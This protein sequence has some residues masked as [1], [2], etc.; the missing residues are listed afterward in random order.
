MNQELLEQFLS[1]C[2]NL[3]SE[4]VTNVIKSLFANLKHEEKSV[5]FEQLTSEMSTD[6]KASLVKR[7]LGDGAFQITLGQGQVNATNFFNIQSS[8]PDYLS[9]LLLAIAQAIRNS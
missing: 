3:E 5:I 8:S 1:N 2:G 9:D 4:Q 6:I 7:L